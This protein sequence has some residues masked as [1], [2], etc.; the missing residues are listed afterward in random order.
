MK[1]LGLAGEAA[2]RMIVCKLSFYAEPA[3][4]DNPRPQENPPLIWVGHGPIIGAKATL[5]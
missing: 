2:T 1:H 3:S 4:K 5:S